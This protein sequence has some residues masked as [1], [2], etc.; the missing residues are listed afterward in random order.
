MSDTDGLGKAYSYLQYLSDALGVKNILVESFQPDLLEVNKGSRLVA[1]DDVFVDNEGYSRLAKSSAWSYQFNEELKFKEYKIV[2][3]RVDDQVVKEIAVVENIPTTLGM[4][5]TTEALLSRKNKS[6]AART[7]TVEAALD[8]ISNAFWFTKVKEEDRFEKT[9]FYS[10]FAN[11]IEKADQG[12]NTHLPELE[13]IV[14]GSL[15]FTNKGVDV[16]KSNLELLTILK[17]KYTVINVEKFDDGGY[18]TNANN[19]TMFADP[20][21]DENNNPIV[22]TFPTE[23]VKKL[24]QVYSKDKNNREVTAFVPIIYIDNEPT[25]DFINS[26]GKYCLII[27]N[28]KLSDNIEEIGEALANNNFDSLPVNISTVSDYRNIEFLSKTVKWLNERIK[29]DE[30]EEGD[31]ITSTNSAKANKEVNLFELYKKLYNDGSYP[32]ENGPSRIASMNV[33]LDD[34]DILKDDN[35]LAWIRSTGYC[36]FKEDTTKP[37]EVEVKYFKFVKKETLMREYLKAIGYST[38]TELNNTKLKIILHTL[39]LS[40]GSNNTSSFSRLGPLSNYNGSN[41][42]DGASMSTVNSVRFASVGNRQE[43]PWDDN[44]CKTGPFNSYIVS[45]GNTIVFSQRAVPD[46]KWGVSINTTVNGD[47]ADAKLK[48]HLMN[49]LS[50]GGGIGTFFINNRSNAENLLKGIMSNVKVVKDAPADDV[51][52]IY[53]CT[54]VAQSSNVAAHYRIDEVK[55]LT[56]KYNSFEWSGIAT[57]QDDQD[58]SK[59]VVYISVVQKAPTIKNPE[60]LPSGEWWEGSIQQNVGETLQAGATRIY[61]QPGG[62]S[63]D[64]LGDLTLFKIADSGDNYKIFAINSF[65]SVNGVTADKRDYRL[66]F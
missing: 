29:K 39:N 37:N 3:A 55:T 16:L 64:L 58:P 51:R 63:S 11:L 34:I 35:Y 57:K 18:N 14:R 33:E 31:V 53:K 2:D 30:P 26:Y 10:Q 38:S 60:T 50:G 7:T 9:D 24:V 46:N 61:S 62:A 8:D 41:T 36:V 42:Y 5:T 47:T 20:S 44:S 65:E 21:V 48:R 19:Y 15:A 6:L 13:D 40:N 49:L 43:I 27:Y 52:Y 28:A 45:G 56:T 12:N 59:K 54:W 4:T 25:D 66:T 32:L 1:G 23:P 22:H 17:N